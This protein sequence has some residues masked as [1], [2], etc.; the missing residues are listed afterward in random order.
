MPLS[1]PPF[2]VV[3]RKDGQIVH[4]ISKTDEL[5]KAF[6]TYQ[7]AVKGHRYPDRKDP[8]HVWSVGEQPGMLVKI[9]NRQNQDITDTVKDWAWSNRI[10]SS[11]HRAA[12][13]L[14]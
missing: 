9:L 7:E 13:N 11:L 10:M 8:K 6:A 4:D 5:H 1:Q 2:R 12:D 14:P 3:F